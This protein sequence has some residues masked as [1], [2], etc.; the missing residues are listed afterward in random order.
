MSTMRIQMQDDP[1]SPDWYDL[2]ISVDL[3]NS[4]LEVEERFVMKRTK[5]LEVPPGFYLVRAYLPSGEVSA[6]QTTIRSD[7]EDAE[8]IMNPSPSP[9]EFLAWQHFLGE[10]PSEQALST[11]GQ[12]TIPKS[13]I[14]ELPQIWLRLWVFDNQFWR[15]LPSSDWLF[16]SQ[17]FDPQF[18][19]Y[20]IQLGSLPSRSLVMLQVGGLSVPWRLISLPPTDRE[21]EVLV[22]NTRIPTTLNGGVTI[23]VVTTD[24]DAETLSHYQRSGSYDAAGKIYGDIIQRVENE[25]EEI[26]QMIAGIPEDSA[27]EML[28]G[29]LRNP[30]GALIG[31]YYL[32][33]VGNYERMHNWPNNFATWFKWLPDASVIHAWQLLGQMGLQEFE[34]AR[35]RLLQ[36]ASFGRP[37]FTEGLRYLIDGLQL[38]VNV[39]REDGR[40]DESAL[41]ALQNARRY[42]GSMDW[43]QRFV[44]FYGNDPSNPSLEVV[45]GIPE[46]TSATDL[47]FGPNQ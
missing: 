2:P 36:A 29:K 45:Y 8:V 35:N 4:N 38:C 12:L 7:Q 41:I 17:L 24:R 20:N 23:K 31:G 37:L 28:R 19:F 42:A 18:G 3:I 30:Y 11:E 39:A 6:A 10:V 1:H 16:W 32:L 9:H 5:T 33:K 34:R 15:L 21:I 46:D 22:R 44:T 26:N 47:V 14:Q 40:I 27:E 25:D 13:S 43:L